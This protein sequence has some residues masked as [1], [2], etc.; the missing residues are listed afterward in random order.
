MARGRENA[1]Y[2]QALLHALTVLCPDSTMKSVFGNG[3]LEKDTH[4]HKMR[5]TS[6]AYEPSSIR[7]SAM[8]RRFK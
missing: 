3:E 7:R 5:R 8:R 6:L 4:S 2:S 1:S